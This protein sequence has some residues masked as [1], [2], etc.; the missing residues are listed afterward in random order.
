MGLCGNL[1]NMRPIW[2]IVTYRVDIS[3]AISD[4]IGAPLMMAA[5]FGGSTMLETLTT[6]GG[7]ILAQQAEAHICEDTARHHARSAE[8]LERRAA[9]RRAADRRSIAKLAELMPGEIAAA[10]AATADGVD[11]LP[12]IRAACKRARVPSRV[13][14]ELYWRTLAAAERIALPTSRIDANTVQS[15]I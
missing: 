14:V 1:H 2:G 12:T 15:S 11:T 7:H 10:C 13:G 5:I 6:L 3:P 9:K 4:M 8:L